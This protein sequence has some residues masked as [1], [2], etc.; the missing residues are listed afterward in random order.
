VSAHS[1]RRA[2]Q[3]LG[4]VEL[5]VALA[6]VGIIVTVVGAF[7][8]FQSRV[9]RDT[10]AR[11]ELDVRVRGVAEALVQDLR[12]AGA[13]AVVDTSGRARF[14]PGDL[15][16]SACWG[17]GECV[18]VTLREGGEFESMTIW[19]ASS[20]YLTAD[21]TGDP[22]ADGPILGESCREV[23]Y[24]LD[25]AGGGES[26]VLYRSDTPCSETSALPIARFENEFA[27]GVAGIDVSFICG[28]GDPNPDPSACFNVGLDASDR[29]ARE[30]QVTV[31]A[32]SDRRQD[33]AAAVELST[34]LANLRAPDRFRE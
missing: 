6:V 32:T 27:V 34:T 20:L 12:M 5:L 10:Q 18:S 15:L 33:I 25:D 9:S 2:R 1:R 21:L 17:T 3:G 19:Y 29:F 13:R 14:L 16:P 4:L 24:R 23:E 28:S 26:Q 30:A 7:F 31:T 11:N 22:D 8:A